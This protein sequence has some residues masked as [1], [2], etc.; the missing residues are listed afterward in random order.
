M[1]VRPAV[2]ILRAEWSSFAKSFYEVPFWPLV[3]SL[4]HGP[5]CRLQELCQILKHWRNQGPR[6]SW[7]CLPQTIPDSWVP[8]SP[9]SQNAKW[10]RTPARP[11]VVAALGAQAASYRSPQSRSPRN[12]LH[13]RGLRSLLLGLDLPWLLQSEAR[14][15]TCK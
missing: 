10:T 12:W 3:F 4:H 2:T 14:R 9:P 7:H 15:L 13:Q 6:G 1:S 11:E 5:R 8:P